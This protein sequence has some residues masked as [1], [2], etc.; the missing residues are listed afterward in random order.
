VKLTIVIADSAK[1]KILYKSKVESA[2]SRDD[3][4]FSEEEIGGQLSAALGDAIQKVFQE[5]AVAQKIKEVLS[6]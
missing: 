1:G 6:Q 3:V 2:S 4:S 5:K